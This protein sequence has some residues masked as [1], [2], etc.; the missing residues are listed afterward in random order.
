MFERNVLVVLSVLYV[1]VHAASVRLLCILFQEVSQQNGETFNRE[2]RLAVRL[3]NCLLVQSF[4]W[5]IYTSGVSVSIANIATLPMGR[6][7]T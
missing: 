6:S 7:A 5:D 4:L 3:S 1:E 2:A